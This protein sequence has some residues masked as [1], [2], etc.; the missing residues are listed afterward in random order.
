MCIIM[1]DLQFIVYCLLLFTS[2]YIVLLLFV[3]SYLCLLFIIN[4]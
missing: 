2:Y 3:A 4:C 1:Y